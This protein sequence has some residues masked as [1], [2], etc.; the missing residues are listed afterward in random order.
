MI[1]DLMESESLL[2]GENHTFALFNSW[3]RKMARTQT[4][5]TYV[6]IPPVWQAILGGDMWRVTLEKDPSMW[7]CFCSNK[8]FKGDIWK[9]TMVKNCTNAVNVTMQQIGQAIQTTIWKLKME[10]KRP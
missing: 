4:N 7:L 9:L 2:S 10:E 3:Q 5:A 8:Q 1:N 6:N